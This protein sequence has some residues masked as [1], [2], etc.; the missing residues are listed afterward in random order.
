MPTSN[1]QRI[2]ADNYP[3]KKKKGKRKMIFC[4]LMYMYKV[5][6]IGPMTG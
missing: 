6:Y 5:T 2:C 3:I 4:I 1:I